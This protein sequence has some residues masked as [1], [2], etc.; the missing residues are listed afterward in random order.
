MNQPNFSHVPCPT[1]YMDIAAKKTIGF[2]GSTN[3]YKQNQ[4]VTKDRVFK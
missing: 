4:S 3:M 2:K 1:D